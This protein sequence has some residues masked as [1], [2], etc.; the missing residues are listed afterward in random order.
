[1]KAYLSLRRGDAVSM[2]ETLNVI[3]AIPGTTAI[4]EYFPH[5]ER[6]YIFILRSDK[7]RASVVEVEQPEARIREIIAAGIQNN[8]VSMSAFRFWELNLAGALVDPIVEFLDGCDLIYFVP[9]GDIVRLPL[10][11]FSTAA[12][13]RLIEK[14]DIAYMPSASL[15]RFCLEGSSPDSS[16]SLV[17]AFEGRPPD[18]ILNHA[19]PE[20]QA[21]SSVLRKA[22]MCLGADA[23]I[24]NL[25]GKGKDKRVIHLAC[26]GEFNA[27]AP[28]SSCLH[29]YD[30]ALTADEIFQNV[31]LDARLVTLSA[32]RT[33]QAFMMPGDETFGLIRAFLH[34]G[35]SAILVSLW[36]LNDEKS[37][38]FMEKFYSRVATMSTAKALAE[39]ER[40][41]L[42]G[43]GSHPYFWAP[44]I[45]IGNYR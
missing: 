26:H 11:A 7:Q 37:S 31:E 27:D 10:H 24:G 42:A 5:R 9:F 35:V 38:A 40:E 13:F 21:V 14:Y 2:E 3:G 18:A 29:L 25:I 16:G 32:C 34:A 33:G 12:G 4:V 39:T 22:E 1:V 41:M 17:M 44:F 43:P 28:M 20:A 8:S 6:L 19:Y 45:L 36:N 15:L 30:G 23:T